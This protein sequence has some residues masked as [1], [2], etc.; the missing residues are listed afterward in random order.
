MGAQDFDRA[1]LLGGALVALTLWKG[2]LAALAIRDVIDRGERL[3]YTTPDANGVILVDPGELAAV[4]G[5]VVGRDVER[6]AYALARMGRSEGTDG[7]EYRMHVALNDL[8]DLQAHGKGG[9]FPTLESL[10]TYSTSSAE[11]GLFGDQ[12][13]RR[14][15]TTRDPHVGDL[16][17]AEKVLADRAAGLDY[18]QGAIKFVDKSSFGKQA[19][20][21]TYDQVLAEWTGDGLFP[22]NLPGATSNFVLFARA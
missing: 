20:T 19:G 9:T 11:R 8:A 1:L 18:A 17:L 13:G 4:A 14:Y 10:F 16:L 6:D 15:A 7:R 21:R 2:K 22:F 3:T 5:A 12:R